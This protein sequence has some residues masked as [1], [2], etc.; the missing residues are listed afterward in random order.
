MA[1]SR[2]LVARDGH[3]TALRFN[4]QETG[5]DY[6][7]Y[8]TTSSHIGAFWTD[9]AMKSTDIVERLHDG[10]KREYS[11]E[12]LKKRFGKIIAI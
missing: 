9:S 3:I 10:K 2:P 5:H 4:C 8:S 1:K 12:E 6:R 11:R 7:I